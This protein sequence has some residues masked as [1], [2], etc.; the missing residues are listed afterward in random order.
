MLKQKI[1]KV[2][3]VDFDGTLIRT[4][5]FPKWILFCL[6]RSIKEM[7]LLLAVQLVTLLFLRKAM[8]SLSH[9]EFKKMIND[10]N[11][12]EGWSEYFCKKL[13][14]DY[15]SHAVFTK[16]KALDVDKVILT[17]AA[18]CCYAKSLAQVF[19]IKG[20]RLEVLC[21]HLK[22]QGFFDNYRENKKGLTLNHIWNYDKFI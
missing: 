4:N 1:K 16:I 14:K 10:L 19:T 18:P 6:E 22:K 8:S 11:Y 7:R 12:P 15:R 3:C 9:V 17:T 20:A 5:S 2:V 13:Y 21:S